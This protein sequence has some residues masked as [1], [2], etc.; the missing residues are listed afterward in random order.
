MLFESLH[1]LHRLPPAY[2][3]ILEAAAYLY[4]IGHYVND[5][6]HHKHS[7]YLIMNSDLPGFADNERMTIATLSRY[8]R[9]SMPQPSHPEFQALGPE[10]RNAVVLLARLLRTTVAL[11][12]SKDRHVERLETAV[13]YLPVEP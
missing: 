10:D 12:Q 11:G 2:G 1:P 4:N 5:S 3:R 6:R 8:H 7:L 9:K 13:Q